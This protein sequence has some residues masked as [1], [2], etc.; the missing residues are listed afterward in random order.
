MVN[1]TV[2]QQSFVAYSHNSATGELLG[3]LADLGKD[4][5]LTSFSV[6]HE[7][8]LPLHR[9]SAPHW[10]TLVEKFVYVLEGTPS[11]WIDGKFRILKAGDSVGFLAGVAHAIFNTSLAPARLLV[12]QTTNPNDSIV[13]V[14]PDPLQCL[15]S[16]TQVS[17]AKLGQAMRR[18]VKGKGMYAALSPWSCGPFDGGCLIVATALLRVAGRGELVVLMGKRR[19]A[20]EG[21][22]AKPQHVMLY[23]GDRYLDADGSRTFS[24]TRNCWLDRERIIIE[25]VVPLSEQR[26]RMSERD[27]FPFSEQAVERIVEIIQAEI[28]K[29]ETT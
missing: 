12:V 3:Q 29:Q 9:S 4:V 28:Q 8:L 5:G 16:G 21:T 20:P 22:R 2:Q 27:A 26:Q 1:D 11:V 13:F 17:T 14:S 25:S 23:L 24:A 6:H 18:V 15:E 7:K 10:H 19:N